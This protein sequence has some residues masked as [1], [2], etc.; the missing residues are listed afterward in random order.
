[1]NE[2]KKNINVYNNLLRILNVNNNQFEQNLFNDFLDDQN[3]RPKQGQ[4]FD[5][6]K[7]NEVIKKSTNTKIKQKLNVVIDKINE[8][9][10][11]V[12]DNNHC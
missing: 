4:L 11:P 2:N 8:V 12:K 10:K 6:D 1:M 5:I 3:I 9:N 7:C